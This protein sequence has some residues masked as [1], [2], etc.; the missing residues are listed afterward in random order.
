MAEIEQ[1]AGQWADE[2]Q[3]TY[4]APPGR[5]YLI[6]PPVMSVVRDTLRDSGAFN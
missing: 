4:N 2:A 5:D 1:Q 6:W 3:N